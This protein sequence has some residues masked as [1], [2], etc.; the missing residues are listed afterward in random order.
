MYLPGLLA[1]ELRRGALAGGG[2]FH[3]GFRYDPEG[4][5]A[6]DGN[7]PIRGKTVRPSQ[8]V[9]QVMCDLG[10]EVSGDGSL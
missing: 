10:Y 8:A 4:L 9:F 3:E 5:E 2:Q 1:L 6:F 7:F